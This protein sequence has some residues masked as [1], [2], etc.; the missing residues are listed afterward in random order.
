M[1]IIFVAAGIGPPGGDYAAIL[2]I[3]SHSLTKSFCFLAA[4]AVLLLV[5]T[6]EISSVRG[7]IR[8]SPLA[9][10]AL[11]FG[12]LA[13]GGAPPFAVFFSEFSI[14]RA[15]IAQHRYLV[16][17]LLATFIT[18]AFFGILQHVNAMVFG[19]PSESAAS[20]QTTIPPSCILALVLAAIPVVIL[21]LYQPAWLHALVTQAAADLTRGP[22]S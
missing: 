17:G 13:I 6:R 18:I 5:G 21:G 3:V 11:L 8:T 19:Q 16:V 10:T 15:A 9:S 1:G 20:G 22:G 2:Q 4:G 14:F 12:A 7:L